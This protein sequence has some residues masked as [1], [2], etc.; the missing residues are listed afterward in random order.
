MFAVTQ[1]DLGAA[2]EWLG[3]Y[4]ISG[5]IVGERIEQDEAAVPGDGDAQA[6]AVGRF[7]AVGHADQFD[8][9]CLAVN[10]V[11]VAAK[12]QL[13]I[14]DV[15]ARSKR[16][17]G[18]IGAGDQNQVAAVVGNVYLRR[19]DLVRRID[20]R[21]IGHR[22]SRRVVQ[23]VIDKSAVRRE[24]SQIAAVACQADGPRLGTDRKRF[25]RGSAVDQ[26]RAR[27]DEA[28]TAGRDHSIVGHGNAEGWRVQS[29]HR[30]AKGENN[31]RAGGHVIDEQRGA[32]RGVKVAAFGLGGNVI[33]R[34]RRG[35]I[36]DGR[37]VRCQGSGEHVPGGWADT[38]CLFIQGVA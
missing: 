9:L 29:A 5:Q 25:G 33:G 10:Q 14:G 38:E 16:R 32:D 28:V 20:L 1:V 30:D 17:T 3:A 11:D 4:S 27:T 21:P 34:G 8:V 31:G 7:A 13:L 23:G 37:A 24:V 19:N 26:E 36:G 22:R 2:G 15:G 35:P 6:D 12:G 18:E